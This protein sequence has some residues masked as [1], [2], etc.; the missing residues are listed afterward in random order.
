MGINKFWGVRWVDL[1]GRSRIHRC[2]SQNHR[3]FIKLSTEIS[4]I[5]IFKHLRI[6]SVIGW[7]FLPSKP[8]P[9]D[10]FHFKVSV[11]GPNSFKSSTSN[12]NVSKVPANPKNPGSLRRPQFKMKFIFLEGC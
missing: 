4:E 7:S 8:I 3:K 12:Q 2:L 1:V 6:F 10:R 5:W 11:N 9:G